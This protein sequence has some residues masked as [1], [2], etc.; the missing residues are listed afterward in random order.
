MYQL[1]RA[2]HA[3][4]CF[5]LEVASLEL[6]ALSG[7]DH[8]LVKTRSPTAAIP[9]LCLHQTHAPQV[10]CSSRMESWRGCIVSRA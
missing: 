9:R 8:V 1:R 7:R 2:G 6:V 4:S 10:L 5:A 3:E